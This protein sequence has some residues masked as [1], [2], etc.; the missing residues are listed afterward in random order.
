MGAMSDIEQIRYNMSS[1]SLSSGAHQRVLLPDDIISSKSGLCIETS[2]V[3]ASAL[4][5]AGM[6]VMLIFPPGH[7]QVAVETW[8]N[9]GEYFLIETTTLPMPPEKHRET[10]RY[11]SK[12]EW[13]DYIRGEGAYADQGPCVVI[14]CALSKTLGITPLSN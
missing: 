11:M 3:L 12:E 1:F 10:V 13:T 6:H 4:Q 5:S 8:E 7:A 2:L 9:S 14:D